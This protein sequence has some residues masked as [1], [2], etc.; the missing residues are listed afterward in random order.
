MVTLF[1]CS[2]GQRSYEIA[3]LEQGAF[4]HTL[5][6]GL[7]ESTTP[8]VLEQYL[9]NRAACPQPP[10]WEACPGAVSGTRTGVEVR[11]S[12]AFKCGDAL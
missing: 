2:R 8:R 10:V 9:T 5:L 1:S 11:P 12:V 6:A 7:K 4:T 3:D